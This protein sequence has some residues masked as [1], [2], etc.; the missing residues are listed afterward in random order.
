Q[1]RNLS[2]Y[3]GTNVSLYYPV[4]AGDVDEFGKKVDMLASAITMQVKSAYM[5]E[6]A[7]GSA[8]NASDPGRKP[9]NA[10]EKMKDEA[11]LVGNAMKLAYL[12]EKIGA[13]VPPV[14][15]A[16]ISDRDLIKQNV[17]TT[18]VRVLLTKGQLSD[19]NDVMRKIVDAANQGLISPADVFNQLRAVAATM[20][21]DPNQLKQSDRKL[22]EMGFVA[23]YLEGLP[24]QSE[25][26][27]LDEETWKS[28][29]GL[30]QEKFIRNLN[31]KLKH[32]QLYNADVDR[33]V[34]LAKDSDQRDHVYPVPLEM[35]P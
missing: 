7:V 1:Y 13:R 11:E 18:D 10:D 15:Q 19:L 30:A 5:G 14:F 20:G 24:Y 29:D 25:V 27:N 26:L 23:E 31:V 35:M 33:W 28:M 17:P 3:G 6:D 8:A 34:A 16:W 21:A 4:N 12:G 32:Y 9:V 2:T 22:S